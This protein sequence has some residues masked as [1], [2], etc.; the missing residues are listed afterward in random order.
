MMADS[1]GSVYPIHYMLIYVYSISCI[2]A[3]TLEFT[4]AFVLPRA[5]HRGWPPKEPA[6]SKDI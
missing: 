3:L 5:Y 4:T 1:R 6:R 2:V